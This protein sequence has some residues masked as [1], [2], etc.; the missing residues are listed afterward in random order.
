MKEHES[1]NAWIRF[2]RENKSEDTNLEDLVRD[3]SDA[4][5]KLHKE[6]IR[7]MNDEWRYEFLYEEWRKEHSLDPENWDEEDFD[8]WLR[9]EG[10]DFI[11]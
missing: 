8:Q 5:L 10:P 4:H 6:W 2:L 11:H 7:W 3:T 9:T 1:Q